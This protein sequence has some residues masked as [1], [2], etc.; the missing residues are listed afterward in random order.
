MLLELT[1]FITTYILI[2]SCI[3]SIGFFIND[4]VLSNQKI[5]SDVFFILLI[6]YLA[7][8]IGALFFHFFFS[9]NNYF[10]IT[11]YIIGLS[12]F[13][14]NV[15]KFGN[16]KFLFL[17]ILILILSPFLFGYSEHPIDS[18]M[19][20]HPFIAYLKTEKIIF[21]LANIQFRFGHISL[22]QYVQASIL[23]NFINLISL[24]SINIIFFI[25]FLYFVVEKIFLTKK[26]SYILI[27]EVII[28]SYLLIKFGRYREYGNDLI[29][30][31]IGLYIFLKILYEINSKS[32]FSNNSIN[33]ILP[34]FAILIMHKIPYIFISLLFIVI[35]DFKKF[36]FIRAINLRSQ[37]IFFFITL[38][39]L[40]KNY[41]NTSCFVYPLEIS[42]FNNSFFSLSGI[43]DPEKASWL[44]EI[45][46][47][48]FIDHPNW[49]NLNLSTYSSDFNWVSTWLRGHF[50]KILEILS[51][52]F[53][54]ILII[55]IYFSFNRT[56]NAIRNFQH[57]KKYFYLL[58]LV[59]IGLIIWFYKAPIF[60][61]GSF[62][63]IAFILILYLLT[64]N[65][66]S[67]HLQ[68][69][70]LL[71]FKYILILSFVF[72]SIKN[73]LRMEKSTSDFF[74]KN[75]NIEYNKI[76]FQIDDEYL[77]ILKPK[78]GSCYFTTNICSHE[79]PKNI[80]IK[81]K[82]GY[83]VFVK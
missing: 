42:C 8:G 67:F 52:V 3:Y 37:I 79:L 48:G 36:N 70:S 46:A 61:Y 31:L 83:F 1:I 20:H 19:Y 73:F 74:P 21:G 60:R 50:I 51:P 9:I 80:D 41:I 6:G 17:L 64:L 11:L 25:S 16:K 57:I 76:L 62:Y 18:N 53:I 69:N 55:S 23:N 34:T 68:K 28:A 49:K 29:P 26:F 75:S 12:L 5:G 7:I 54:L 39:W 30:L 43:S 44:T 2:F 78:A 66:F 13:L 58:L 65:L 77:T 71:I 45:W 56:S 14:K 27:I 22:L 38:A 35:L 40:I 47:K 59:S 81:K 72:F 33:Y 24:T 63:I 82:F 10:S 32:S 4:N 15:K